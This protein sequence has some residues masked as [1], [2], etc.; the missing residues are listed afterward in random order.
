[1]NP[2]LRVVCGSC[3]R[4]VEIDS[5]EESG[6][7]T[8]G[9]C[10]YCGDRVD[11]DTEATTS[12]T[13]VAEGPPIEGDSR[14]GQ[15][16]SWAGL[17][18]RGSLGSLGRFQLRERLGDG[19][20]GEVYL[21]F[22]PRLDRDVAIKVLKQAN[23]TERVMERFFREARAAARLDHPN[24]VA[25]HDAGF[26]QGRCWVSFHLVNGRPLNWYRDHHRLDPPTAARI[27]RDL[28]EAVDHA[29]RQG[30]IHR[31]LK[32]GNVLIDDHGRP[33]LIDFGLSRRSDVESS[34]TRDGAIVG[35]PAYMSPEQALGQSRNVDERS[36]VFSLGVMLFEALCGQRPYPMSGQGSF[37]EVAGGGKA[38]SSRPRTPSARALNPAVPARLDRICMRAVAQDPADRYPSARALADDLDAWLLRHRGATRLRQRFSAGILLG[39]TAATILGAAALVALTREH[40]AAAGPAA[41]GVAGVPEPHAQ[42]RALLANGD[43]PDEPAD[44]PAARPPAK[45]K[46]ASPPRA[47]A[48]ATTA[49]FLGS[50]HSGKF[51][52][53]TCSS[54][55]QITDGN[56][57]ELED[58]E[59]ATAK[60]LKPC[61]ICKPLAAPRTKGP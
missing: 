51:H 39:L 42:A 53:P 54:V 9:V 31:D 45:S 57:L 7:V 33:R 30:V 26:D 12:R 24:I 34:L 55:A 20:F 29:H 46:A 18:S 27:L 61:G 11:S 48:V 35:T 41:S 58:P 28:A 3:L 37:S 50:T 40:P 14:G 8:G 56:L 17:W 49:R 44:L 10:P 36:D 19:G 21:A 16:S 32:P 1:M 25:V 4:S 22:D 6:P 15:P 47:K 52:L 43:A 23:P 13:R 59:E 5:P 2:P 60:S 38:P